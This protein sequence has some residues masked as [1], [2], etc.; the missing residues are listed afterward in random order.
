MVD[1]VAQAAIDPFFTTKEPGKG[2]GHGLS[3]VYGMVQQSGGAMRIDTSPGHGTTVH[4]FL[5][6]TDAVRSADGAAT[7]FSLNET[8]GCRAHVL[9]VDDDESVR[10]VTSTMLSDLGYS[11]VVAGSGRAGLN[12]IAG[13]RF[14]LLLID[15]LYAGAQWH[16]N[17]ASGARDRS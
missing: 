4:L 11:V 10:Q 1:E 17:R 5:P 9:I 2:S 14:D 13:G 16:R 8:P 15:I 12:V 7:P 3:Q 6:Q